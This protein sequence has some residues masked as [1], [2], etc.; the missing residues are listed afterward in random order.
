MQV[1][2]ILPVSGIEHIDTVLVLQSGILLI[3][4]VEREDSK[5]ESPPARTDGIGIVLVVRICPA[6][7]NLSSCRIER[8][9]QVHLDTVQTDILRPLY[10]LSIHCHLQVL[11]EIID[12]EEPEIFLPY[13]EQETRSVGIVEEMAD[14]DIVGKVNEP[15]CK[16]VAVGHPRILH[17]GEFG[18]RAAVLRKP[19]LRYPAFAAPVQY[20]RPHIPRLIH[21]YPP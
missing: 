14:I 6:Q 15:V 12:S 13:R 16:E 9:G 17:V 7:G 2:G 21:I 11:P 5:T 1:D 20:L 4:T 10:L 8:D 3:Q 18:V 19:P